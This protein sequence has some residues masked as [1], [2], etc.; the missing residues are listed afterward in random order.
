MPS[1]AQTP[2]CSNCGATDDLVSTMEHVGGHGYERRVQ[3]Q[4][5][6]HCW[7]RADNRLAEL[8]A[9]LA[10]FPTDELLRRVGAPRLF[11]DVR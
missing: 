4:D 9:A 10:N 1:I 6:R 7:L 5:T 3:C 8:E 11:G 2:R